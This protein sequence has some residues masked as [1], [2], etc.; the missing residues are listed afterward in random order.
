MARS[1]LVVALL[2]VCN[3]AYAAPDDLIDQ[4]DATLKEA[5]N[6]ADVRKFSV[7]E[8][9]ALYFMFGGKKRKLMT[10]QSEAQQERAL[11]KQQK[12]FDAMVFEVNDPDAPDGKSDKVR[13]PKKL[14]PYQ[15]YFAPGSKSG[16]KPPKSVSHMDEMTSVLNQGERGTCT[17]FAST[18]ALE[19]LIGGGQ[20]LSPEYMYWATLG[21]SKKQVCKDPGAY[22]D[23]V[24]A[25]LD[26]GGVP[27]TIHWEYNDKDCPDA[28]ATEA[29]QDYATFAPTNTY[30]YYR[31]TTG[32][33]PRMSAAINDPRFLEAAL[34][35][36][37]N[38]VMNLTA[39]FDGES[40]SNGKVND[41]KIKN[42]EPLR[43]G[44]S[45]KKD[46]D[47]PTVGG[48]EQTCSENKCGVGAHAMLL[49]GYDRTEEKKYGGGYFVFKNSWGDS[50]KA[51]G[52]PKLSYDFIRAYANSGLLLTG[53][54]KVADGDPCN[55]SGQCRGGECRAVEK[56][57]AGVFYCP[58]ECVGR[59]GGKPGTCGKGK[60]EGES[61]STHADCDGF[62]GLG[63]S[64]MGCCGGKCASLRKDWAGVYYCKNQCVGR[65][66]ASA[67]TCP[68]KGKN[69]SCKVTADCGGGRTCCSGKCKNKK[70]D[71]AGVKYCP[72]ECVGSFGGKRG[73]CD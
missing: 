22:L 32:A 35:A 25:A 65:A 12:H 11:I 51:K 60:A 52:Y 2:L 16:K 29:A 36:G 64:G 59:A 49:M 14:K 15:E 48:F 62:G 7:K 17:A 50:G 13:I 70:K 45:C 21:R 34:D 53:S 44:G 61:C 47:C 56:D 66:G 31:Q 3:L 27:H 43:G 38:V 41:V 57:W 18:A 19:A 8:K 55:D 10:P 1:S 20:R 72:D 69:D 67:G 26:K 58:N 54:G 42:G 73:T 46:S 33:A 23:E 40:M 6:E 30:L 37:Y 5:I 24:A 28:D 39:F 4:L 68:L 63:K 71:W 9:G